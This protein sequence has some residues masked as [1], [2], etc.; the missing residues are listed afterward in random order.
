MTTIP[1][2]FTFDRHYVLAAGV[3]LHTLLET[4]DPHYRYRLYVVHT[5]LRPRHRR[6]LER[7]VS[8]FDHARLDFIDASGYQTGWENFRHK[9][10][11]SKEIFYKLTAADLFPQYDRILFSDVD[12]IF[13]DDVA[14]AYFL[15]P[16]DNDFYYAG[17]R[18][19]EEN[20]NLPRYRAQF[21]P[22]EINAI[23][24]YEISAGFMLI[25]LRQL[26]ADRRQPELMDYFRRHAGRLILPEQDCIALCLAPHIRFLDYKYVVCAAQFSQ[27]PEQVRYNTNNPALADPQAA[28]EIYRRMLT[29]VVQLHYPGAEK[30]WNNPFTP[31]FNLWFAACRRAGLTGYWLRCQP[32][33]VRQ[34]LRRYSLRRFIRKHLSHHATSSC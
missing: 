6:R 3:A 10:H 7:V 30:P 1:I 18:P 24:T 19:I 32:L 2:F 12:V 22:E 28:A 5:D 9:S 4:A 14:P 13:T 15:F 33:F 23:N 34:R 20:P 29:D 11:F 25:N 16:D 27:Q 26:R 17:T 31:R 21:T 8:R